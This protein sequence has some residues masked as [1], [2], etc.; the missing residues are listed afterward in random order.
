MDWKT[1]WLTIFSEAFEGVRDGA[2]G[3]YF[4]QGKEAFFPIIKSLTAEQASRR[5]APGVSTI[6]AHTRHAAYYIMLM[7]AQMRG[8]KVEADWARSWAVQV[9][10]KEQWDKIRADLD[11]QFSALRW[12]MQKTGPTNQATL[13]YAMA[14]LAHAAFHLGS[15][16]QLAEIV[17]GT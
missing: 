7:N 5:V 2:D 10:D 16:R 14:Q 9:V 3:T 17:K 8:E 13:D 1:S 12:W 15:V 4:V 6:A 11:T